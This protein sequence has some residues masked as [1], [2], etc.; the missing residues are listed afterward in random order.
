MGQSHTHT[1]THTHTHR[2]VV[3]HTHDFVIVGAVRQ[4]CQA[5]GV[6][7][8][9]GGIQLDAIVAR[10]LRVERVDGDVERAAV[11]LELCV[12]RCMGGVKKKGQKRELEK[13]KE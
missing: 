11:S 9:D 2:I 7:T 5:L 3:S 12:W 10:E 4:L 13:K 8:A 6:Q 1:H